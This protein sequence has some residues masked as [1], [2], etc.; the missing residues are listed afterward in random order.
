MVLVLNLMWVRVIG[1]VA[2]RGREVGD[3][4]TH[5]HWSWAKSNMDIIGSVEPYKL[6]FPLMIT[7]N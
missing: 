2:F 1:G 5:G 3:T 7:E 6:I 4:T